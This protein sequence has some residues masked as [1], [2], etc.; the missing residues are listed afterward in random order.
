MKKKILSA[1][2][3]L[4]MV[5]SVMRGLSHADWQNIEVNR[6]IPIK[7]L[8]KRN[9]KEEKFYIPKDSRNNKFHKNNKAY[10]TFTTDS[11]KNQ[12]YIDSL[13]VREK[14]RRKGLGKLLLK[15]V[16]EYATQKRLKKAHLIVKNLGLFFRVSILE[17]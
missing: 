3:G 1:V 17:L 8:T 10:I 16:L 12:I 9:V 11:I 14:D 7:H 13:Y 4:A 2:L 6:D 15:K 5:F